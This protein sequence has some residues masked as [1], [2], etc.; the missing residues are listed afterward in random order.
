MK[1]ITQGG[2]DRADDSCRTVF[3]PDLAAKFVR[4]AAL[5]QARSEPRPS[6]LP[7]R[8]ASVLPPLDPQPPAVRRFGDGPDD[9]DPSDGARQGAIFGGVGAKLVEGHR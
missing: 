6:R 3:D 8:R 7:D 9:R 4:E 2:L 1:P 5:D